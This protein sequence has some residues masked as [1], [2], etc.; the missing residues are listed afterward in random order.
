M[1]KNV[2]RRIEELLETVKE[3]PKAELGFYDEL[4]FLYEFMYGDQYDYGLQA[5]IAKENYNG[6]AKKILDIGCGAGHLIEELRTLFG[7]AEIHGIDL[8]QEML[9]LAEE[10]TQ[11]KDKTHLKKADI[12][13]TEL[14]GDFDIITCFGS[15]PHFT[16]EQHQEFFHIASDNLTEDGILVFDYKDPKKDVNGRYTPWEDETENYKVTSHFITVYDDGEPYY[17]NSYEFENKNTGETNY[18]GSLI[19]IYLHPAERLKQQIESS[20]LVLEEHLDGKGD[21]SGIIVARKK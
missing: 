17:T 12:F 14:E 19:K 1:V 8:N 4:A 16:E 18:T 6:E 7:N 11:N 20:E 21:Q 9:D 3:N 5:E 13:E 15:N 2:D 10:K